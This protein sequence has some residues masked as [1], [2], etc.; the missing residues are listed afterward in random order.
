MD[1]LVLRAFA[2]HENPV[3]FRLSLAVFV[4]AQIAYAFLFTATLGRGH[5]TVTGFVAT[6][7]LVLP[8]SQLVPVFA[9]L[10]SFHFAHVDAAI[11]RLGLRPTAPRAAS[12]SGEDADALWS[13]FHSK[14]QANAGFLIEAIVEAVPQALLQTSFVLAT[15]QADGLVVGSVLLSLFVVASKGYLFC[16]ALDAPTLVFN[17]CCVFF[18]V[19]ALFACVVWAFSGPGGVLK[20]DDESNLVATWRASSLIAGAAVTA[21]LVCL[22]AFATFDDHLKVRLIR[23]NRRR[24]AMW[25]PT[26]RVWFDLYAVRALLL[27]FAPLP[28]AA[29][30]FTARLSLLPAVLLRTVNPAHAA[31][32]DAFRRFFA[33]ARRGG[34]AEEGHRLLELNRILRL[35]NASML[36][37]APFLALLRARASERASNVEAIRALLREIGTDATFIVWNKLVASTQPVVPALPDDPAG[38]ARAV[39]LENSKRERQRALSEFERRSAVWAFVRDPARAAEW[40]VDD[41]GDRALRVAGIVAG[42]LLALA[43]PVL[44]VSLVLASISGTLVA[45]R[46]PALWL[47]SPS[48]G[49]DVRCI[50]PME[51]GAVLGLCLTAACALSGAVALLLLPRV[52]RFCELALVDVVDAPAEFYASADLV[53]EEAFKRY[54]VRLGE[55]VLQAWVAERTNRDCALLVTA[56]LTPPARV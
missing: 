50:A 6:F 54:R 3:F 31:H 23:A 26:G 25:L 19:A 49:V 40:S 52:T 18:D 28:V 42:T 17:C 16:F 21:A 9:W 22:V 5:T 51:G 15:G 1:V 43:T 39:R 8:F 2:E 20:P 55:R 41:G 38:A 30:A 32:P 44:A 46:G 56:F 48:I 7:L 36:S 47:R 13:F 24:S 29:L 14:W 53:V 4:M 27:V 33:F 11:K 45:A 10:E 37:R 34:P 12:A 35:L